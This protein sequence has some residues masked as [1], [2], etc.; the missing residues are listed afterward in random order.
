MRHV[1]GGTVVAMLALAGCLGSDDAGPPPAGAGPMTENDDPP[2]TQ[3]IEIGNALSGCTEVELAFFI[4][5]ERAQALLPPG[6]RALDTAD[7]FGVP[8]PTGRGSL[9]LDT[10]RCGTSEL[11][12]APAHWAYVGVAVETPTVA[13]EELSQEGFNHDL[14]GL[15]LLWSGPKLKEILAPLGAPVGPGVIDHSLG[16]GPIPPTAAGRVEDASG[17]AARFAVAASGRAPLSVEARYW[18]AGPGGLAYFRFVLEDVPYQTGAPTECAFRDGWALA[19]ALGHP[20][21]SGEDT[22]AYIVPGFDVGGT[23]RLLPGARVEG[24]G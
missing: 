22:L 12:Q 18:L 9:A 10:F 15:A 1:P 19:E 6:W 7:P 2:A 5:L 16:P 20:D 21:C 24:T 23:L 14:Y 4:D 17:E 13:G 11:E 8:A 3:P